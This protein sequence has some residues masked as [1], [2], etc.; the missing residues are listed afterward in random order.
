LIMCES[1]QTSSEKFYNTT[2]PLGII[3]EE[4]KDP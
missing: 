2:I 3:D 1:L 4:Q